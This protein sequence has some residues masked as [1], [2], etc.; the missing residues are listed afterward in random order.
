MTKELK[1]IVRRFLSIVGNQN[2]DES[3]QFFAVSVA[4]I[5]LNHDCLNYPSLLADPNY[6]IIKNRFPDLTSSFEQIYNGIRSEERDS[7][8]KDIRFLVGSYSFHSDDIIS[9]GYQFMKRALEK[10]A[11]AKLGKGRVKIEGKDLLY[12]TQFFTDKYMTEYLVNRFCEKLD[13]ENIIRTTFYDPACGGGNFIN[14]LA[15]KC[16]GLLSEYRPDWSCVDKVKFILSDMLVGYDLDNNL[17]R[18]ASISVFVNLSKYCGITKMPR[19]FIFGGEHN[20]LL[21]YIAEKVQTERINNLSLEDCLD[22]PCDHHRIFITNPPFMGRRD[23]SLELKE[24]LNKIFPDCN[25][26]LCA[27][28]MSKSLERLRNN[29]SLAVVAQS[30]WMHLK[31]FRE[32]RK[33]ILEN[34]HLS[35]CVDLGT[36]AFREINGEKTSVS[37]CSFGL[38]K[39]EKTSFQ[40]YKYL[41][42]KEKEEALSNLKSDNMYYASQEVFLTNK[43][44]E[45]THELHDSFKALNKLPTYGNFATPMQGTSTGDNKNFV[46]YFW[47]VNDNE[48]WRSVSKGGGFSKWSGLNYFKVLWGENAE[49]IRNN[50]GSAIRNLD[51]INVTDL[52]Y[53]DT[54]TLGLNI[55][56]LEK[57]QVFIASG[58]G[59]EVKYGD[60]YAHLAFLNSRLASFLLKMKNPKFTVSAGY[61]SNLPVKKKLLDS[62]T[63]SSYGKQTLL[64]KREYLKNKLPNPEFD[65]TSSY[66]NTP[67]NKVIEGLI[68]SDFK[69]DFSRLELVDKIDHE[70]IESFRLN[71]KELNKITSVVGS[72]PFRIKSGQDSLSKIGELDNHISKLLDVNCLFKSK[73]INGYRYGTDSIVEHLSYEFHLHPTEVLKVVSDNLSSLRKTKRVFLMD[74]Y[75]KALLTALSVNRISEIPKMEISMD[76]L[77]EIFDEV[78][79]EDNSSEDTRILVEKLILEHHFKS[80]MKRPFITLDSAHVKIGHHQ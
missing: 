4:L 65:E 37:L 55:R 53:S 50:P 18:I 2:I 57:D 43:D 33:R 71:K 78:V 35:D 80:F 19:P 28:F 11:F 66:K 24:K 9:W 29:D 75:H 73:S 60:K 3:S 54:G 67:S 47:E 59:I 51:K 17:A 26:D 72:S 68:L 6:T 7:I 30:N 74:Y 10:E 25:A 45:I 22:K 1:Q 46:K 77:I 61:I 41:S 69:N 63:L 16:Y 79:A 70:I 12:T 5:K 40:N 21:G 32:F 62:E 58:P 76:K 15:N 31:S 38:N 27:S 42:Y 49:E 13:K 8:F 34:Y 39:G 14:L 23:M 48:K 52:V 36:K 56:V 44:F 20:D 64:M